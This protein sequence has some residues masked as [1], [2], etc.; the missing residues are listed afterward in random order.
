MYKYTEAVCQRMDASFSTKSITGVTV[1]PL[2]PGLLL[3]LLTV[4]QKKI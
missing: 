3:R 1:A 2:Q 4:V